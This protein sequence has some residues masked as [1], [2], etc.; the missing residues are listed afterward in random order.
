MK[1]LSSCQVIA[2]PRVGTRVL[3]ALLFAGIT[4]LC[5]RVSFHVWFTPVPITLQVFAVILSGLVLGSRWGAISQLQYLLMGLMGAPVFADMLTGPAEFV[6]PSG[7]YLLGFVLGAFLAGLVFESLKER[8]SSASWIAGAIG[9]LG[10]Y[11]LGASWLSV[12][13][14]CI[15]GKPTADC[16]IGAWRLGIVPFIGIDCVKAMAASSLALGW[17]SCGGLRQAFRNIQ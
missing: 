3:T 1:N 8:T 9:I 14:K 6:G 13:Q 7:G 10:I 2:Q 12:W 16:I 17:R 5:A 15:F 11:L 4:A